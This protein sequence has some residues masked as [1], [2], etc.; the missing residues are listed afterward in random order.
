VKDIS[1]IGIGKLGGALTL[2]LADA[3]LSVKE[4]IVRGRRTANLIKKRFL[5]DVSITTFTSLTALKGDIILITTK[6]PEIRT[7]ASHLK[8][9]VRRGQ[10]VLHTSGSLPSTVLAPLRRPGAFIGSIH[11]LTS[12]SNALD[13]AKQFRGT[14]FCLEGDPTALKAAQGLTRKLGGMPFSIEPGSKPIYHAAA[15]MAA[16]HVT[17]LFDAATE[18]MTFA[19]VGSHEAAKILLPLLESATSNLRS[20][21]SESALTGTFARLDLKTFE[22]HLSSLEAAVSCDLIRIYLDLGDRSLGLV[23]RRDGPS[24]ELDEFRAAI[25]VA[26]RK[27]R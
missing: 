16:G 14:Y 26:R 11:P 15:V 10:V 18:I 8:P 21:S 2:A 20:R 22:R 1:V 19:G 25:S 13:G 24:Q 6:D 9:L 17:A 7:V 3:G 12:V 23:Q 5:P 27:L 4:L